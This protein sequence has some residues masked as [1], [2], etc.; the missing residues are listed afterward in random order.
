M[1][2]TN[3]GGHS[4][5]KVLL[6]EEDDNGI[7][8]RKISGDIDYNKRLEIQAKKQSEFKSKRQVF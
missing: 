6:C 7:F 3:L 1:S 8:V 2:I 5:C 4:G